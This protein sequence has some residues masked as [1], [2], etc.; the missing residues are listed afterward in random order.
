MVVVAGG[1]GVC[2]LVRMG[3]IGPPFLFGAASYRASHMPP[4]SFRQGVLSWL[5]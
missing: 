5:G 3:V 1:T 2:M 4:R